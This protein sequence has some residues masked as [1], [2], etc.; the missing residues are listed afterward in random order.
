MVLNKDYHKTN[1]FTSINKEDYLSATENYENVNVDYDNV[2]RND[3]DIIV[4]RS[5]IY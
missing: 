5:I 3:N 2:A 1:D 4:I